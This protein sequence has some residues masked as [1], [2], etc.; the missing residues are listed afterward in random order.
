VVVF[1]QR[2]RPAVERQSIHGQFLGRSVS[3]VGGRTPAG[4][5]QGGSKDTIMFQ[6]ARKPQGGSLRKQRRQRGVS[7]VEQCHP[8]KGFSFYEVV[9]T[10][11]GDTGKPNRQFSWR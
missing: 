8:K 3:L 7:Q 4:W 5:K 10:P 1:T 11:A 2:A 9:A 6:R